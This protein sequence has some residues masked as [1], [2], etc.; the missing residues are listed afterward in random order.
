MKKFD[1]IKDLDE[2]LRKEAK[3]GEMVIL[4]EKAT[5][6]HPKRHDFFIKRKEKK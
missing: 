1:N 4:D 6:T 2:Y 3:E 5:E